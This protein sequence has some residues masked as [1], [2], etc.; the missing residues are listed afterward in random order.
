M[1]SRNIIWPHKKDFAFSIIDDTDNST[2][3][4]ISSIYSL[5]TDL[6]LRTTKTVWMYDSRDR[7]IGDTIQNEAYRN[8]LFKLIKNGFEVQMHGVG[9]GPFKREEIISGIEMYKNVF[10]HY[11]TMHINHS[12]NIYNIYWGYERYGVI[13]RSIIKLFYG[14]K[15]KFY[16]NIENSE[17]FWGDICKKHIKYIRNRVFNGINTLRIDKKMPFKVKDK[18]Y[19]NYWFSCSDGHS[20][21][22]FNAL[23]T[24][25][26]IEKLK[27]QKGLCIVYTHFAD[28]FTDRE[29]KV[30]EEFKNKISYL[31]QQNGWFAT[32]SEIL[33]H[34]LS[35]K[36]TE[37][38]SPLYTLYL[39]IR[40]LFDRVIKKIRFKK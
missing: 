14:S 5:L 40:W 20:V 15:R 33:D 11:P 1:S 28:G 12:K 24:K 18:T 29:G 7:F 26:N 23:I 34:L 38:V 35:Y 8:F 39:D 31:S 30:N 27:R 19:S 2:L 32:T 17:F 13:V 3:E 16:G 6:N 36:K 10:S 37:F 22:E 4:N 25:K 21:K 9:S